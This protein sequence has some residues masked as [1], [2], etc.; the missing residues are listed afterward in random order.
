MANDVQLDFATMALKGQRYDEAE[1]IYMNLATQSSS[2]EA[3][4][5]LGVTKLYQLANGRTV[6]ESLFCFEKAFAI[7]KDKKHDIDD[8]LMFH[9]QIVIQAYAKVVE[10]AVAKHSEEQK[11]AKWAIALTAASMVVGSKS[12][13]AY[14][15]LASLGAT[16]AGVGVAVGAFSNMNDLKQIV[17]MVLSKS[18]EIRAGVIKSV[19][20]SRDEYKT[21]ELF[22]QDIISNLQAV[23][24]PPKADNIATSAIKSMTVKGMMSHYDTEAPDSF[25]NNKFTNPAKMMK[26]IGGLFKGKKT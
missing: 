5:G 18:D 14:G 17:S 7:D 1:K 10:V 11:K 2:A 12:S 24:N 6:D 20:T 13:S 3:W 9:S 22:I 23:L 19:D 15:T 25:R 8:Q 21:F 16:G 26:S 4:I